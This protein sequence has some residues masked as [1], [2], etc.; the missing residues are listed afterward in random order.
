MEGAVF[1]RGVSMPL[2]GALPFPAPVVPVPCPPV[3]VDSVGQ[4][5]SREIREQRGSGLQKGGQIG[6][7]W[8]L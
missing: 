7:R 3:E 8:G 5:R 2:E 6:M 1:P 4:T